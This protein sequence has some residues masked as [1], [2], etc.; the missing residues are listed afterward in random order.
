M[1]NPHPLRYQPQTQGRWAWAHKLQFSLVIKGLC[2]RNPRTAQKIVSLVFLH[3]GLG[4]SLTLGQWETYLASHFSSQ[5][6][7]FSRS[8][9]SGL[10]L[11]K[12]HTIT[13]R[14]P[15]PSK[16]REAAWALSS[17]HLELG[18]LPFPHCR[19][20]QRHGGLSWSPP[21]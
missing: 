1:P 9:W 19:L 3:F 11:R 16:T 17:A 8:S 7:V 4:P 20:L 13:Y 2:S 21:L 5:E 6:D 18:I 10:H 14:N 12:P 15:A